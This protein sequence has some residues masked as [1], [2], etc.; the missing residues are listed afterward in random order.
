MVTC[1]YKI[2]KSKIVK[3]VVT[4][5]SFHADVASIIQSTIRLGGLESN[6]RLFL[7]SGE[8]KVE[9]ERHFNWVQK[10][11]CVG[12]CVV[13]SMKYKAAVC[14]GMAFTRTPNAHCPDCPAL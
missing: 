3:F 7:R 13:T 9:L 6:L 4:S 10:H 2:C 1:S 5:V 11:I 8:G 14:L 12:H